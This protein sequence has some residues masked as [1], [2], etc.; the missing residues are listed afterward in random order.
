LTLVNDTEFLYKCDN[1]YAP[2]FDSGIHY[3]S[4]GIDRDSIR[5]EY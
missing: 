3:D 5:K 1:L 2:E 4:I